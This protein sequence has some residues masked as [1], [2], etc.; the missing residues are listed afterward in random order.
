M[1]SGWRCVVLSFAHDQWQ[2]VSR[3]EGREVRGWSSSLF[4]PGLDSDAPIYACITGVR[5]AFY[6]SFK[7]CSNDT[8]TT[9]THTHAPHP[10]PLETRLRLVFR[11]SEPVTLSVTLLRH[12]HHHPGASGKQCGPRQSQSEHFDSS[13][14]SA[15]LRQSLQLSL[16]N[17]LSLFRI[18]AQLWPRGRSS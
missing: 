13:F 9:H 16:L 6:S 3:R 5:T 15:Y 4:C 12:H 17:S 10:L 2:C 18:P 7:N 14:R 8:Y 1:V 11:T